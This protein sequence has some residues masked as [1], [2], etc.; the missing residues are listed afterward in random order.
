MFSIGILVCFLAFKAFSFSFHFFSR[1]L[2]SFWVYFFVVFFYIGR[3]YSRARISCL[4]WPLEYFIRR[5]FSVENHKRFFH[6]VIN[7]L[8]HFAF[9]KHSR[10]SSAPNTYANVPTYIVHVCMFILVL[11]PSSLYSVSLTNPYTKHTP[12]PSYFCFS[13]KCIH[14]HFAGIVAPKVEQRKIEK[15]ITRKMMKKYENQMIRRDIQLLNSMVLFTSLKE[16]YAH[17]TYRAVYGVH[18]YLSIPKPKSHYSVY[19]EIL[20]NLNCHIPLRVFFFFI[21]SFNFFF[22]IL[23]IFCD[24]SGAGFIFRFIL[25]LR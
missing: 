5:L 24:V 20:S 10:Q 16:T 21:S 22:Y 1:S 18:T 25:K 15:R 8:C 3:P 9:V 19:S 4:G 17:R 12:L 23:R 14:Q 6:L 11:A 2:L 13:A 7:A